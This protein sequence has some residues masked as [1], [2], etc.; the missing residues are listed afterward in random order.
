LNPPNPPLAT[1]LGNA[2]EA[3]GLGASESDAVKSQ[4]SNFE[5]YPLWHWQPMEYVAKNRCDVLI[6]TK[7]NNETSGGVEYHFVVGGWPLPV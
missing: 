6:L 4:C 2:A 1:P 5:L 7:T 3:G